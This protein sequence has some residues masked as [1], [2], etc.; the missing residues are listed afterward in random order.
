MAEQGKAAKKKRIKKSL[1]KHVVVFQ[2]EQG[3]VLKTGFVIHGQ[4]AVPPKPPVFKEREEHY[5]ILF[6]GWDQDYSEKRCDGL[7][8]LPPTC[9]EAHGVVITQNPACPERPL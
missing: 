8:L 3:A 9:Q 6:D 4:A 1:P 7:A 2:D 5:Q